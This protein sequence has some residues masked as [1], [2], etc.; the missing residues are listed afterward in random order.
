M[1]AGKTI[2]LTVVAGAGV[3]GI[4][5]L[6]KMSNAAANI[7]TTL[8]S[9]RITKLDLSGLYFKTN[10]NIK[11]PTSEVIT[12]S[13]PFVRLTSNGKLLASSNTGDEIT[14]IKGKSTTNLAKDVEIKLPWSKI[15]PYVTDF[16]S[17]VAGLISTWK[18]GDNTTLKAKL[19]KITPLEMTYSTTINNSINYSSSP[20]KIL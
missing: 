17:L 9:P 7:E 4:V 14:T 8:A 10:V 16:V 5:K 12:V 18:S 3:Y 6:T 15:L 2:F 11:N 20:S 1:G 13:Q 19:A